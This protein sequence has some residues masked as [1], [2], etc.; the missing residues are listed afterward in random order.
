MMFSY[1]VSITTHNSTVYV[2][3][4][5]NEDSN[6]LEILNKRQNKLFIENLALKYHALRT[7]FEI[8]I[9]Y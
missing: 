9:S 8:T 4:L 6:N 1:C 3:H 2:F 5:E 7:F